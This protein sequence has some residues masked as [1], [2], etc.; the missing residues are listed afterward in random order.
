M[1][2]AT[3][4]VHDCIHVPATNLGFSISNEA[5]LRGKPDY[6]VAQRRYV[7]EHLRQ[8]RAAIRRLL[9]IVL[10]LNGLMDGWL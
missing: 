6:H 10:V 4:H 2:I 9:I 3:E 7:I 8:R 1:S 5:F